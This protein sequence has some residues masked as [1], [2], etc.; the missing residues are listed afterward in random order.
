MKTS[1]VSTTAIQNAVRLTVQKAQAEVVKTQTEL[2]TL[3]HADVG[4]ALGAKTTTSIALGRDLARLDSILDTNALVTQRLSTSQSA[5]GN[6]SQGAQTMVDSLITINGS[7]DKG[8]IAIVTKEIRNALDAMVA[9]ANLSANG[10]YLFAGTNSDVKPLNDYASGPQA[11]FQAAFGTYLT[12]LGKTSA[13]LTGAEMQS[14]IDNEAAALFADPQWGTVWSDA[15]DTIMTSRISNTEVV[16]SSTSANATGFREFAKAA[17]LGIELLGL[18]LSAEARSAVEVA[19]LTAAGRAI[20]GIDAERA[21]LGVSEARVKKANDSLEA[22]KTI[23]RNHLGSLEGIDPYEAATR[24]TALQ[25][26]LE[27][28]YSLTARIQRLSLMN[29]L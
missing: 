4:L 9:A 8:G 16:Q 5:L 2:T 15:S 6:I 27:A 19:S 21:Q 28:S 12:G 25:T 18:D 26:Q 22:Q 7:T 29:Y 17:V 1:F 24:M 10:E 20:T 3:R 11:A 23:V 13:E 14:F